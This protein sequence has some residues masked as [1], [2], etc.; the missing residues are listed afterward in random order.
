VRFSGVKKA[1]QLRYLMRGN[2]DSDPRAPHWSP[3]KSKVKIFTH[4]EIAA[5]NAQRLNDVKKKN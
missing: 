1:K 3:R 4:E 2:T 5:L